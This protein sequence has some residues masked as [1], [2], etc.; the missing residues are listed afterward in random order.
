[1]KISNVK[2]E[3]KLT[4][5][6]EGRLDTAS[7]PQFETT[8]KESLQDITELTMDMKDLEYISSAALRVLLY[9]QKVMNQQGSMKLVNVPKNIMGIFEVTGF[10]NILTIQSKK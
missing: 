5:T 1:M 9:T 6:I 10:D 2:N 8:V 4:M 7:A 3:T